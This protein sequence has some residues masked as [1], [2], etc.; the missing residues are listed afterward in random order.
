MAKLSWPNSCQLERGR[1]WLPA[2][3]V[4]CE[5][6]YNIHWNVILGMPD[7]ETSDSMWWLSSGSASEYS[8]QSGFT[9]LH[10]AISET[11]SICRLRAPCEFPDLRAGTR[12]P[13]HDDSEQSADKPIIHVVIAYPEPEQS[14]L[15]LDG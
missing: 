3:T 5:M 15:N 9:K 2:C 11:R 7:C 6:G 8:A 12:A 10:R 1:C 4:G 14:V 13:Y